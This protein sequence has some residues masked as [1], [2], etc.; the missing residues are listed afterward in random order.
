MSATSA[1]RQQAF[2][3]TLEQ[4]TASE[5]V[6][7]ALLADGDGFLLAAVPETDLAQTVAAIGATLYQLAGRAAG[8]RVVDE[9]A[10]RFGD[11]QRLVCRP[12][13]CEPAD[14]LLSVVVQPSQ[15]YRRLTNQAI[16]DICAV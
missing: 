15:A 16:R 5:V 1:G 14:L 3:A 13:P 7:L 6:S 11:H 2:C 8:Q 12:L 4:L 10:I 9:I